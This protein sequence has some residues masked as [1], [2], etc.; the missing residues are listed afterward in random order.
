MFQNLFNILISSYNWSQHSIKCW[1]FFR[2]FHCKKSTPVKSRITRMN[3]IE[4][5][6]ATLPFCCFWVGW[7][8]LDHYKEAAGC[9]LGSC[10]RVLGRS[11]GSHPTL[12]QTIHSG[13]STRKNGP[14]ASVCS[15]QLKMKLMII[16]FQL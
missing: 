5:I 8:G 7:G 13:C 11:P 16:Q 3:W 1:I 6:V 4:T 15:F 14:E 9:S 10:P 12:Q 2:F